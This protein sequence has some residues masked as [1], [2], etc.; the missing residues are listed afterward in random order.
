MI[1]LAD[2]LAQDSLKQ[3]YGDGVDGTSMTPNDHKKSMINYSLNPDYDIDQR[4]LIHRRQLIHRKRRL[5][6]QNLCFQC[7]MRFYYQ[8]IDLIRCNSLVCPNRDEQRRRSN[9]ADDADDEFE[10]NKL[11][12]QLNKSVAYVAKKQH[13]GCTNAASSIAS[14]SNLNDLI[15][16]PLTFT[17]SSVQMFLSGSSELGSNIIPEKLFNLASMNQLLHPK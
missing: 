3:N 10:S 7:L 4:N 9:H 16:P 14:K 1:N 17:E 6:H 8:F 13:V 12:I 15:K 2:F 5:R 11:S